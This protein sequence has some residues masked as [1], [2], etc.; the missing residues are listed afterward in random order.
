MKVFD[1]SEM[2]KGWFV[3]DFSPSVLRL[4]ES[5]AAVKKYKAGDYE[6]MHHHKISSEI[7]V[8][9]EGVVKMNGQTYCANSILLIEPNEATDFLA[10]TDVITMV[11]KFPGANDD[12]Y[13][14]TANA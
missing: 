12:K 10:V 1:L 8:I 7:T 4:G 14:G 11:I 3:G 6:P 5:E 13:L 9:A 2:T